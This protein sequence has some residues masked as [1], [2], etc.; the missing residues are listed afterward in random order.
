MMRPRTIRIIAL[1]LAL[2]VCLTA[3]AGWD[4]VFEKYV[5]ADWLSGLTMF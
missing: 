2:M 5:T 4:S 1:V 3:F